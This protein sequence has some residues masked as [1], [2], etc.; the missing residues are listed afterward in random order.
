MTNGVIDHIPASANINMTDGSTAIANA[1]AADAAASAA[2]DE[3]KFPQPIAADIPNGFNMH[4]EA[5]MATSYNTDPFITPGGQANFFHTPTG[6]FNDAFG[7]IPAGDY[8]GTFNNAPLNSENMESTIKPSM[9]VNDFLR[10][11]DGVDIANYSTSAGHA[12][13]HGMGFGGGDQ[14]EMDAMAPRGSATEH[15]QS[16]I[17]AMD[18]FGDLC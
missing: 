5:G 18:K 6:T 12:G 14:M 16:A 8:A 1:A 9:D 3:I 4:H 2:L 15:D 17:T 11:N 13:G 10:I 7:G